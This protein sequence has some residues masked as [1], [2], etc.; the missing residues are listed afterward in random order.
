[1]IT[2]LASNLVN[3]AANRGLQ[4]SLQ[5]LASGKRVK[6]A[7]DDAAGQAILTSLNSQLQG[8]RQAASNTMDVL[9][10]ADTAGGA[11]GQITDSLQ[12][13]RELA[14]QA[15]NGTYGAGDLKSLQTEIDQL[16]QGILET[17]AGTQFNGQPL[18]DGGFSATVQAGADP[19]QTQSLG[20]GNAGSAALGVANLDVSSNAN[21]GNAVSAIDAA[22][23][24]L[25]TA[26]ANLGGAQGA[27]QSTLDVNQTS[28]SSLAASAG[29]LGDT[30]YAATTSQLSQDKLHSQLAIKAVALYNAMQ[31]STVGL[32]KKS[33]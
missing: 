10:L 16:S 29:R 27:L 14:V 5:R 17:A 4:A 23:E 9:A 33:P 3:S 28:A 15:A 12:R 21:A 26:Q 19:G 7:A 25:T 31:Q 8:Q 6:S 30:D 22:L 18:L 1:V 13:M 24:Q 2:P 11:L 32:L 20:L